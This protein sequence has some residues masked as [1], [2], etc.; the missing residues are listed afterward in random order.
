MAEEILNSLVQLGGGVV[1][2]YIVYL[3]IKEVL[4]YKNGRKNNEKGENKKTEERLAKLEKITGNDMVHQFEYTHEKLKE[5][6]ERLDKIDERLR[7]VEKSVAVI[8][9]KIK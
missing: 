4:N 3:I 9:Y 5:V 1:M 8:K 6:N 2:T 7:R